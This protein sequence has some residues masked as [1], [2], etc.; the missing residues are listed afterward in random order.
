MDKF[1]QHQNVEH[2]RKL[3]GETEDEWKRQQI[4][5]LLA[6]EE[7]KGLPKKTER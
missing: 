1:V 4:I 3:L 5:K 2:Y 6:E 7:A